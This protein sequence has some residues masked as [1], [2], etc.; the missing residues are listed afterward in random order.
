MA[1]KE[2]KKRCFVVGPIGKPDG[3]ERIHSDWLLEGV[4]LPVFTEH[5]QDFV[6]QRADKISKAGMINTQII[7]ELLDAELVIADITTLNPNCFYEIGIRHMV[8]KPIIHMHLAGQS[9]PF[10]IAPFRSIE[11]ARIWPKDLEKARSDL[12]AF[13]E[14]V[15]EPDHKVDNPVT[16]ARGKVEFEKNATPAE[17]AIQEEL[18]E[19]RDRVSAL[20]LDRSYGA[21]L[22]VRNF[23]KLRGSG[24]LFSTANGVGFIEVGF[25][26]GGNTST[27]HLHE[28][29]DSLIPRYLDSY[30][31][32]KSS[33]TE[34]WIAI[35]GTDSNRE[36]AH[37]LKN[38]AQSLDHQIQVVIS[39]Q[40]LG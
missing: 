8:Q 9:I 1:K 10:D 14:E 33:E 3:E 17:K 18:S 24:G 37:L 13:I 34:V 19:L 20:T 11:F 32:L 25:I 6:V 36:A 31:K 21:P 12:K 38:A 28:L 39:P 27:R 5:F 4:I 40:L 2:T 16:V 29:V 7:E 26:A 30:K 15:L 35:A 22:E 23:N